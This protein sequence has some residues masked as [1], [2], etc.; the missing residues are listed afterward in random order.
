[1]KSLATV[2]ALA[3]VASAAPAEAN[4][5]LN[6]ASSVVDL[7]RDWILDGWERREGDPPFVFAEKLKRFYDFDGN[8]VV[9]HDSWDPQKRVARSAL[10]YGSFFEGAFNNFRSARH[11]VTDGPHAIVGRDLATSSL[12]FVARLE[13]KDGAVS[14]AR[15][16]SQIVWRCTSAGWRIVREQNA[17]TDE[18][19]GAVE[20]IL[21]RAVNPQST[22]LIEPRVRTDTGS[23]AETVK[24]AFEAWAAGRG[25]IF[26]DLLTEKTVW[27]IEGSGPH[28][29]TYSSRS[30]FMAQ[31]VAPFARR[32]SEPVRPTVRQIVADGSTVAVIW[33]GHGRAADGLPYK[34]SYAWIFEMDG[35]RA[36][37]VTAFLDLAAYDDVLRRIPQPKTR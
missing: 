20:A 4:C 19:I 10:E 18:N 21:N 22:L 7:H 29:K 37:K 34:N 14:A 5:T 32:L 36:T 30:E 24:R 35:E 11:A 6:G 12:E 2:A 28:A 17:V 27:T 33:D 3:I 31:A 23:A 25:N 26:D 1:M 9:I 13:T 15:A 16:Q 8:G